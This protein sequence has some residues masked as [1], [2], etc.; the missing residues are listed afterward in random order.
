MG[1]VLKHTNSV[2]RAN[3]KPNIVTCGPRSAVV[4]PLTR[5]GALRLSSDTVFVSYKKAPAHPEQIFK[6][7]A[8]VFSGRKV[9]TEFL[10]LYRSGRIALV[11]YEGEL[12]ARL[13]E[14]LGEGQPV[15]ACFVNDGKTGTIHYDSSAPLGV[16]A[17]F[18]VHE[19][20]HALD[21]SL[22]VA[23]NSKQTR[24]SRDKLMLEAETRAF[25]LQHVFVQEL[26]DADPLFNDFIVHEQS[27][28]RVLHE[29]LTRQD[30]SELYGLEH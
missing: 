10:K 12:L 6:L 5:L 14:A 19:M 21:I 22:W 30:I 23:S 1:K 27:R 17:P 11:P 20:V 13:R 9:L 25:G 4:S 3:S 29:K 8:R 7:I 24:R 26:R 15:G 16:L 28:V 2:T 18:L